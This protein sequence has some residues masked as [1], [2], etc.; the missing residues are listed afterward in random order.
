MVF[1]GMSKPMKPAVENYPDQRPGR[2]FSTPYCPKEQLTWLKTSAF[3][4]ARSWRDLTS[5]IE[6]DTVL[7]A[8]TPEVKLAFI[9][10][11]LPT[12]R[13]S[14][15]MAEEVVDF[16]SDVD[17]LVVNFEGTISSAGKVFMAQAHGEQVISA[18]KRLFPA[19]R[20][21]VA[22]ANNH[23]CDFGWREFEKSRATLRSQGFETIGTRAS[24]SIL[25]A[26]K[27]NLVNLTKWSNRACP[28]V[29]N[30][31]DLDNA[32]DAR[33]QCNILYPHWGYEN[34]LYPGPEQIEYG[35]E[36]LEKWDMILGHHSHC[37]QPVAAYEMRSA[38]KLLAYSLG[39]F[40]IGLPMRKYRW[41]ILVKVALGPD[42][43]GIW[44]AG[45]VEWAFSNVSFA[46]KG[47]AVVQ[48]S[49]N[50]PYFRL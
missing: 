25:L 42:S 47:Q 21:V 37:P 4:P 45:R 18:L 11:I 13:K 9:G 36:L 1:G 29:A 49:A 20:T 28:Y 27:I 15:V 23:A 19:E 14:L 30:F 32:F 40:S 26:N 48:L 35:R 38:R 8:I 33:A 34:Q 46:R 6:S 7:N 5:F 31:E 22:Q 24:P 43:A 50:C 39:D 16:V 10:D 2:W 17:Y 12:G 41:G 44:R 3:G